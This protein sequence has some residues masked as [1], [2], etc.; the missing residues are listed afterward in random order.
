LLHRSRRH[1]AL[2]LGSLVFG[3]W[4]CAPGPPARLLPVERWGDLGHPFG[5][6]LEAAA[7][8]A[9]GPRPS[10]YEYAGGF[11]PLRLG[12]FFT[13]DANERS[14]RS[15]QAQ[16][17]VAGANASRHMHGADS[18]PPF[19]EALRIDPTC[20]SAYEGA[21]SILL[22][23]GEV[24]RCHALAA[25]G[26]RI[27][28]R[29][30]PLWELL[31]ACYARRGRYD[32]ARTALEHALALG[33]SRV[34]SA[35]EILAEVYMRQGRAASAESL[36]SESRAGAPAWMSA[37]VHG[38]AAH[39]RGELH[40]AQA[41]LVE[42][43]RD[44]Q[45]PAAVLVEWGA[46]EFDLGH[47]DAAETAYSRALR[48]SPSER[49]A[50]LGMG[51]VQRARGKPA[52]A[53]TMFAQLV[54]TLP[55]DSLAQFDLAGAS[56]DAA[57]HAGSTARADS[58]YAIAEKAFGACLDSRFRAGEARERRAQIR[59]RRGDAAG[60]TQDAQTLLEDP[61]SAAEA[62]L[63]LARAAMAKHDPATAVKWL[64]PEF[65]RD[66]LATDAL[67][68]LG[69]AYLQLDRPREAARVLR[70]SHERQP[71]EWQTAMNFGVALSRSGD[72][73]E[74]EAVLRAV[75]EQRPRDPDA[76]QNLAAVLQRRGR[77]AEADRLLREADRLRAP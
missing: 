43:A 38:F 62:R 42:A 67:D 70:R 52:L 47:T 21:A 7:D 48:T 49:A 13:T 75:L 57:Q 15:G 5:D 30:A 74:A 65:A 17:L 3:A 18:L 12:D 64:G 27:E 8:R 50:L 60:A 29:S 26:L 36:L 63:L 77:R 16:T 72:L 58:F 25:Q 44:P 2:F 45:A 31:G 22:N 46:V 71:G 66:A 11:K 59:L 1:F 53:V 55:S 24:E 76:L 4:A 19:I 61:K 10:E 34:P 6:S 56:L 68:V 54:A 35:Y 9:L 69:G 28:E 41:A 32:A 33:A 14:M 40:E 20:V 39:Q 51:A 73:E 37:Y 23:R